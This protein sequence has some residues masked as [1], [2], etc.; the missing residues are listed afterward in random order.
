MSSSPADLIR[1]SFDGIIF[2]FSTSFKISVYN[3]ALL[4][5]TKNKICY[6]NTVLFIQYF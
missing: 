1:P 5:I 3:D 6:S 4:M 2:L